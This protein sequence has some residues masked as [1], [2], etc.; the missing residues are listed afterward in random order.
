MK[1]N[2]KANDSN[3]CCGIYTDKLYVT[4]MSDLRG[5]P[6][7]FQNIAHLVQGLC[8]TEN[9]T[10]DEL[11]FY[12]IT[13]YKT[14]TKS[15]DNIYQI[16]RG[17]GCLKKDGKNL[18]IDRIKPLSNEMGKTHKFCD[19]KEGKKLFVSTYVPKDYRELFSLPNT[20]IATEVGGCPS[21]VEMQEK[22]LLG[23]LN[24]TIQS[25]D[26][27]EFMEFIGDNFASD[28]LAKNTGDIN[29]P[30]KK[31][32][33]SANH[34]IITA[35]YIKLKP[36]KLRPSKNN[37]SRGQ[38]IYNEKYDTLEYWTGKEWRTLMWSKE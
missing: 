35:N 21:P 36:S 19:F 7:K 8:L 16:E 22:T 20:I 38:I 2:P 6:C 1:N 29:S 9:F 28:I 27:S 17:I 4:G 37:R 30:A 5:V 14:T 23:R 10:L 25:I 34:S 31:L 32:T 13:E 33:L 11:F 12:E 26:Q 15:P 3:Y 24:G 18:Y